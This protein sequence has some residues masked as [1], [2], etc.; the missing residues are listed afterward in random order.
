MAPNKPETIPSNVHRISAENVKKGFYLILG[1]YSNKQNAE[2]YMFN[3]RQKGVHAEGS[4]FYPTK[5]LY[6]AYSY[7]VSSYEEALKKQKEVNSIKNG[8]PEFEKMKDVW[9]LIVE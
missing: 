4:F 5:N 1:A 6:Y 8:K 2:K 7:Y 9:I 3:L